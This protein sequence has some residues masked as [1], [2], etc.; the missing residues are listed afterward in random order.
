MTMVEIEFDWKGGTVVID[1]EADFIPRVVE[2]DS[3][4]WPGS[5]LIESEYY[6]IRKVSYKGREVKKPK[7]EFLD[8]INEVLLEEP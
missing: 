3:D 6:D 2:V 7:K 5:T 4:P 1:V 8:T